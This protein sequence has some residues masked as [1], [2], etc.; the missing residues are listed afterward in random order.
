MRKATLFAALLLVATAAWAITVAELEDVAEALLV[1][2]EDIN[3]E[4][5]NCPGG[6]CPTAQQILSDLDDLE[7][8]RSDMHSDRDTLDPCANC[9]YLDGVIGDVD[10]E[11]AYALDETGGWEEN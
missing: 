4:I 9:T 11:A 3:V 1:D 7:V 2:Y 10:G 8:E 5:D 6:T